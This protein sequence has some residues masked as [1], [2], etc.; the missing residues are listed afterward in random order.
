MHTRLHMQCDT[1]Q[2]R[3]RILHELTEKKLLTNDNTSSSSFTQKPSTNAS[4][5]KSNSYLSSDSDFEDKSAVSRKRKKQISNSS[6]FESDGNSSDAHVCN[7]DRTNISSRFTS[8]KSLNWEQLPA[9]IQSVLPCDEEYSYVIQS[10]QDQETRSFEGAPEFAFSAVIRINLE[11]NE[12]ID[13]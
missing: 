4:E 3:S 13:N 1:A 6:K 9:D 11:S 2:I 7:G 5:A 8:P 10:Y 12:A